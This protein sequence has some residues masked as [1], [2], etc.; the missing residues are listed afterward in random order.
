MTTGPAPLVPSI[1]RASAQGRWILLATVLGSGISLLDSTVVN[2]ALPALGSDLGA[3][4]GQLQ[5]VVNGYTLSLAALVLLGGSLGDRFGRR[6]VFT[7]G[8]VWFALGSLLCGLAPGIGWLI[9]A[10]I[11]QGVGGALLVPGSLAIISATFVRTDRARAI[12]TW[13]ALSGVATAIGPLLGGWMV[14]TIGWRW[15][16]LINLP[17]AVVVLLVT[18]QHV[19]E[20]SDPQAPRSFDLAGAALAAAGLA[21]LTYALIGAGDGWRPS[22]IMVGLLG[23][24]ALG[25]F[26]AVE[27]RG[28]TPMLPMDVFASRQFSAANL[29]TLVVYAGL[30][31]LFFLLV[32]QLQVVAGFDALAAGSAL[33]PITIIMLLLSG[34]AGQLAERI[35]PRW[36]MTI[37]PLLAG[38]GAVL[39]QRVGPDA[40]YATDVLPAVAVI[41]LGLALTVAPLTA[42]VLAAVED[43]H[44]G[45]ASGVN[46]AVARAGGLLAVAA[47]P[48]LVGLTGD[49]YADPGTFDAGF[50]RAMIVCAV[51]FVVGGII[52]CLAIRAPLAGGDTAPDRRPVETPGVASRLHCGV[53]APPL[54]TRDRE[55]ASAIPPA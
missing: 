24:T 43:R 30:G 46:N 29:V 2:V 17:L 5:W 45:I 40:S 6:R 22:V 47:L 20:T 15:A 9:A 16:F 1:S 23:V 34:S 18:L 19:P 36:P 39:L 41:G 26:V 25:A 33:L 48:V 12:G 27:R 44:A 37:G 4:L 8:V 54:T 11:L 38:V 31:A 7:V 55:G 32:V 52:S 42:T 49:D 50:G 53:G 28:R 35:G 51:L 13:S 21:G 10:R 14:Q 3:S